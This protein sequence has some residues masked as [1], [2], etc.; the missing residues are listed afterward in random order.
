M[1]Q[2]RKLKIRLAF[3]FLVSSLISGEVKSQFYETG[4]DPFSVS[5]KQINTKQYRLIFPT[6][7]E[8]EAMRYAS[9]LDTIY[10]LIG[11]YLPQSPSKFSVVFHTQSSLSNGM[12]VYAPKRMEL[13]TIPPQDNYP[14]DWLD[15][16][17]LHETRHVAQMDALKSGITRLGYYLLGEQAVG[18]VAGLVPRWFLE[19][20]AVFSETIF[21]KAGRGRSAAFS[22]PY[23]A[24]VMNQKKLFPY[25]KALLGSYK[26]FIPDQY[27]M[28]YPM[29]KM[30]RDSFSN[31]LFGN[32]L[33]FSAKY[34]FLGFPFGISL[35][36]QTGLNNKKLY[37]YT[38]TNLKATWAKQNILPPINYETWPV[39][40]TKTFTNYNLP[41]SINDSIILVQKWSLSNTRQF[42]LVNK[43]GKE[44]VVFTPG[45]LSADRISFYKTRITWS[46]STADLRWQN[47]SYSEIRIYDLVRKK[48]IRL[49]KKTWY[50]SPSF[51]KDG[52]DIA[53]VEESP[54]YQSSLVI[55]NSEN[56]ELKLR[57]PAPDKNHLQ[58]PVWDETGNIYCLAVGKNGKA[59]LK[60]D[61]TIDEWETIIPST[62]SDISSFSIAGDNIILAGET[63]GHN[64]IFSYNIPSKSFFKI[65][66]SEFGTFEPYFDTNMGRLFFSEYTSNGYRINYT[67]WSPKLSTVSIQI[68]G[69]KYKKD[70]TIQTIFNLQDAETV[71]KN[72]PIRKF[73]RIPHLFNIHSWTPAYYNYSPSEITN[74]Q[75][76]PGFMV[77]SQDVL[78]TLISSLGYSYE[79]GYSHLHA[80]INYKALYP[81]ISWNI[82]VGGPFDRI[83]GN[84]NQEADY[85][86]NISSTLNLSIPLNLTRGKYASAITPY[87]EW[88]YN[89]RVYFKKS[90]NQYYHG[91]NYIN[92]GLNYYRYKK[93]ATRDLFP[94]LG[95]SSY[96][97][98]QTTPFENKLFNN[99]YAYSLRIY[100]PVLIKHH[101]FQ[102]R[103][104]YQQQSPLAY[105]Y[106]TLLPFPR[107][108]VASSSQEMKLINLDYAFPI[109]YPDLN[110][111][112]IFYIKR[113]RGNFFFDAAK[114]SVSK[115]SQSTMRSYGADFIADVHFLRIMFPFQVG[116]RMGYLPDRGE[117]FAQ[118]IFSVNLVY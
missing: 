86:T 103:V 41:I 6:G 71:S 37:Q 59:L 4:Q 9:S 8:Q 111:G 36:N 15:Q 42:V 75:L 108:F 96:F 62:F 35:K 63:N 115:I 50:Y 24:M 113:I 78:G 1:S 43:T 32:G 106:S 79:N 102:V 30:G 85:T 82:D 10:P 51:S 44:K 117:Y 55:I 58:F 39:K 65:T 101:S 116:M 87:L 16:L 93:M 45:S 61:K 60:Y 114:N 23:R 105:Y 34:P 97:K 107:G 98:M 19:G 47:R 56:G 2:K 57:I 27:Q 118:G 92:W 53:V 77:L 94:P 104:G 28:G 89:R 91:L 74:P 76:Y 112:P 73:S 11:K 49:T 110:L 40:T 81:V 67:N 5:W 22:M 72:Y 80:N 3:I 12:V 88:K 38:Y 83:N 13:Y 48:H 18:V 99:I 68:A 84:P 54:Q 14:Q 66:S 21:S 17:A 70:S 20:D 7:F 31:D 100:L 52:K 46:E 90:D 69:F 29:V 26:D 64:N 95:F 25:D 109:L 33:T